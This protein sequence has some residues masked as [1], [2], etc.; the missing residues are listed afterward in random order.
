MTTTSEKI[1]Q[2]FDCG[3]II[4]DEEQIQHDKAVARVVADNE[5]RLK[6][7]TTTMLTRMNDD[8]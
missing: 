1:K 2:Y 3:F 4:T 7:L 5:R 8:S 6:R